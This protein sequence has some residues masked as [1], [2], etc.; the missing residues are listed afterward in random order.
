MSNPFKVGDQVIVESG[1]SKKLIGLYGEVMYIDGEFCEV[2][3]EGRKDYDRLHHSAL[4]HEV[5]YPYMLV[6]DE[7]KILYKDTVMTDDMY[8][9]ECDLKRGAKT[10]KNDSVLD[11]FKR[12]PEPPKPYPLPSKPQPILP[13]DAQARKERPVFSGVYKYFPKTIE[14]LR[15][16]N[17]N[18]LSY[19]RVLCAISHQSWKGN[20]QHH[21][22]KPLH[23]DKSKSS[24][25]EDAF[26][27]HWLECDYI[28]ATWRAFAKCERILD[29]G[30]KL[31]RNIEGCHSELILNYS[32]VHEQWF[33]IL[34]FALGFVEK[35]LKK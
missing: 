13:E 21:P 35:E 14:C 8:C 5:D 7:C 12:F 25:E 4:I 15:K 29:E 3:L 27:R 22:D 33:D 23:W 11:R 6:C 2:A 10:L 20:Q 1:M 16:N 34:L 24:D 9:P 18:L 19:P 32:L 28:P 26:V 30:G 17:I 31:K